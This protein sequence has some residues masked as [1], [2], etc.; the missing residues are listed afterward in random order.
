VIDM[1]NSRSAGRSA[2]RKH[3]ELSQAWRVRTFGRRARLYAI[4]FFAVLLIVVV[5]LHLNGR[6]SLMAGLIL[7]MTIMAAWVVPDALL[8]SHIA[9]WQRGAWGEQ[10]TAYELKALRREGWTVRHDVKWGARGNHDHVV[11]G[12]AVYVLN[13]KNLKDS[14]M[15]I[16]AGGIR[17]T[18]IDNP[19]NDYLAD[20]WCSSVHKEAWSLKSTLDKTLG[21]P[22]HVYPVVV[23]WGR[24]AAEQQYVGE[25]S[26][27]RGDKLV[28]WIR[29]RPKDLRDPT[30][31]H[32]VANAVSDLPSA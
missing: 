20:R 6:W 19:D 11:A 22:V 31:Q 30:K 9:N 15:T 25:V 16:E 5:S 32:Q 10:M 29:S 3:K 4:T 1:F 12:D 26:V 27:V 23:L 8:P 2:E 17:V 28:E 13:S 21:S 18:R 24:F 7:G 14:E